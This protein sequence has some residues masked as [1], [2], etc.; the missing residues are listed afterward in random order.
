MDIPRPR[1]HRL[2]ADF[3]GC[4]LINNGGYVVTKNE[5]KNSAEKKDSENMHAEPVNEVHSSLYQKVIVPK[6]EVNKQPPSKSRIKKPA[7]SSENDESKGNKSIQSEKPKQAFHTKHKAPKQPAPAKQKQ[8]GI[9][10]SKKLNQCQK[11]KRT[12]GK[13]KP[14]IKAYFLGGLNEIGKNFT[15]F[16]CEG[17]MIIVD[18]GMAFPTDDML[19]VDLVIPNQIGRAHV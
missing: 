19:G 2:P 17:D 12:N 4:T 5:Q 9:A 15:L 14:S 18:C 11:S 3:V 7:V 10:K 13:K 6:K 8:S 1:W 16:E